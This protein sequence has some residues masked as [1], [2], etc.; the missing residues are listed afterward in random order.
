MVWMFGFPQNSY[1]EIL[2][3]KVMV[4]WGGTFREWLGQEGGALMMGIF[5][6]EAS[7]S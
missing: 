4:L 3:S 5:I 2:T 6:K 7:E 1:V